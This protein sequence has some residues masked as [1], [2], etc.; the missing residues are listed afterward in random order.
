MPTSASNFSAAKVDHK[1]KLKMYQM[2]FAY[3]KEPRKRH[4]TTSDQ[5]AILIDAFEHEP[6]PDSAT[7]KQLAAAT[8]MSH[9]AVQV[10]FQNR[11]A[12]NKPS[13]TS[14]SSSGAY[15]DSPEESKEDFKPSSKYIPTPTL[16][17]KLP[18]YEQAVSVASSTIKFEPLEMNESHTSSAT[19]HRHHHHHHHSRDSSF[20]T[21]EDSAYGSPH[22]SDFDEEPQMNDWVREVNPTNYEEFSFMS[23]LCLNSAVPYFELTAEPIGATEYF[24]QNSY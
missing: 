10:W 23:S 15:A 17:N 5:F 3:L 4:R 14:S 16:P 24:R 6:N 9:R 21:D 18:S 8:G 1:L 2:K 11:R 20:A 12:K 19:Y 22:S 13:T 7:R